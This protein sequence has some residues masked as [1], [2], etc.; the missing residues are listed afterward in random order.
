MVLTICSHPSIIL[1]RALSLSISFFVVPMF[2]NSS[3]NCTACFPISCWNSCRFNFTSSLYI[4]HLYSSL[5]RLGACVSAPVFFSSSLSLSNSTRPRFYLT[6]LYRQAAVT[7]AFP[8]PPL[9]F[10]LHF[11]ASL[12]LSIPNAPRF[13]Q[14]LLTRGLVLSVAEKGRSDGHQ[15]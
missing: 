9:D 3:E 7:A 14:Y 12:G 1:A 8:L 11:I 6:R 5:V 10:C 13:N 15:K 4:L 2:S